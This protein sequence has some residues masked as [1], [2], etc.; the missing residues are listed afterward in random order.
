VFGLERS[1]ARARNE[2]RDVVRAGRAG[3]RNC[4]RRDVRDAENGERRL[5]MHKSATTVAIL[6][7]AFAGACNRPAGEGSAADQQHE[8]PALEPVKPV[9]PAPER[10]RREL[11]IMEITA[12]PDAHMRET[13]IVV[14]EVE[15]MLASRAFMLGDDAKGEAGQDSDIMVLGKDRA[16]WKMDAARSARWRVEGT[17]QRI[18]TAN[19]TKQLGWKPDARVQNEIDGE[20]FVLIAERVVQVGAM[21]Q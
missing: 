19:L 10:A 1:S 12:D 18:P 13:V 2:A 17:L 21:Q 15:D 16:S 14:G 7:A 4:E 8:E 6:G 5:T 11:R 3:L 9:G 20:T